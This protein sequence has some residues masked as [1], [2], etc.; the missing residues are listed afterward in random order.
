MNMDASGTSR[1][2]G[3]IRVIVGTGPDIDWRSAPRAIETAAPRIVASP[4]Y[5][6]IGLAAIGASKDDLCLLQH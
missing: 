3:P 5:C 2:A 4:L 1:P 6:L